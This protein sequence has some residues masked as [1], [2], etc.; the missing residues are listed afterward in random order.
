[1]LSGFL[2][3]LCYQYLHALYISET[4][5]QCRRCK[6]GGFDPWVGK[7]PWKGKMATHPGILA[8]KIPWIEEPGWLRSTGLQ[9]RTR[10]KWLSAAQDIV[11]LQWEPLLNIQ[12]QLLQA[13]FEHYWVKSYK[14]FLRSF[15]FFFFFK[16]C[17]SVL[18]K[19]N[20]IS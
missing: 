19:I 11:A 8:W 13:N 16:L 18:R 6:R 1:M 4:A 2:A 9:S 7:I 12:I 14:F 3:I 17:F 20:V 5:C 10:Q 15:I